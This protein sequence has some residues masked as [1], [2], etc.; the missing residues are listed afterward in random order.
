MPHRPEIEH[1]M[2]MF[3]DSLSEKDRRRYAA[4]EAAKLDHGGTAYIANLLGCAT[5]IAA[6]AIVSWFKAPPWKKTPRH[7]LV[8]GVSPDHGET[9]P[10]AAVLRDEQA[11]P[12]QASA[13]HD[14]AI[15]GSPHT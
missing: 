3:Y 4:I 8:P 6:A 14:A 7:H 11:Q 10:H 1:S 13:R 5:L 12:H 9:D 2:R 15:S